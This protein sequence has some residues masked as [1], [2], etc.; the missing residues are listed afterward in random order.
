MSRSW[1][2]TDISLSKEV[3]PMHVS[4]CGHDGGVALLLLYYTVTG[5]VRMY[6]Y[7]QR[8]IGTAVSAAI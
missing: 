5:Y 8:L 3:A 1:L 6:A 4:L 2:S 7:I